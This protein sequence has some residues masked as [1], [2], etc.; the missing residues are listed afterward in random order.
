MKVI[1]I[2][3]EYKEHHIISMEKD[4]Y[5][6]YFCGNMLCI[7]C[8]VMNKCVSTPNSPVFSEEEIKLVQI[9]YPE[10]FI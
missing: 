5:G 4:K 9:E 10:L 3:N 7:N 2:F 1:D 6:Y 8:V